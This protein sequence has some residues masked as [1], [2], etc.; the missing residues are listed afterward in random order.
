MSYCEPWAQ[1]RSALKALKWLFD[2]EA[3]LLFRPHDWHQWRW[4]LK[5]LAQCNDA[6]FRAQRAAAGGLAPTATR[7]WDLV[8]STGMGVPPLERGIAHSTDQK[9]LT[10]PRRE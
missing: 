1:P 3:P 8:R 5:F 10:T 4:G 9:S 2:K 7:A 6:A